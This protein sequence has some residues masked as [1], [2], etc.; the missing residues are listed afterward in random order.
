MHGMI[1]AQKS[2]F[3][4]AVPRLLD[5]VIIAVASLGGVLALALSD[6]RG[7]IFVENGLV[8]TVQLVLLFLAAVFFIRASLRFTEWGALTTLALACLSAFAFLREIPRCTSPFYQFGPCI[9]DDYK[10]AL[11]VGIGVLLIVLI[12]ANRSLRPSRFDRA[13][14]QRLRGFLPKLM[15]LAILVPL[16]IGSQLGEIIDIG[17]IEETLELIGYAVLAVFALRAAQTADRARGTSGEP[18]AECRW[19]RP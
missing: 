19:G 3:H 11:Y 7:Q 18:E 13:A 5:W 16:A 12:A 10:N 6:W 2:A 15:P 17:A 4:I 1:A 8:E 9:S 14:F